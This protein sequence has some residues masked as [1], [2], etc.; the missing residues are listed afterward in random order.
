L[1]YH[2]IARLPKFACIRMN[3]PDSMYDL[4]KKGDHVLCNETRTA[5]TLEAMGTP[6]RRYVSSRLTYCRKSCEKHK[7][8]SVY[9]INRLKPVLA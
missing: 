1:K 2:E 9:V 8:R 6:I 7:G 3:S 5:Q 4:E